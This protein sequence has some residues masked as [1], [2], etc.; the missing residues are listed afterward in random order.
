MRALGYM[1]TLVGAVGVAFSAS[2][3]TTISY[4]PSAEAVGE[5]PRAAAPSFASLVERVTTARDERSL[6][7]AYAE[8]ARHAD[9]NF[10]EM[11]RVV[12]SPTGSLEERTVAAWALGERGGPQACNAVATASGANADSTLGYALALARG[13]CG[14]TSALR[15]VLERSSEDLTYRAKAAAALGLLQDRRSLSI[16]ARLMD[17]LDEGETRNSLVV[18]RG[19]MGDAGVR[20]ELLELLKSRTMHMH[21]A[22]ALARLGYDATIFDVIAATRSRESILRYAA[23][24]LVISKRMTGACTALEPLAGDNDKRVAELAGGA[25]TQWETTAWN[26]WVAEGFALDHFGPRAYCP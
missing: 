16:V 26:E 23:A 11:S 19:L 20:E 1:L 5:A 24:E 10:D 3:Q 25:L 12:A 21:A 2:A 14:D 15:A 4:S 22:I 7:A 13:R 9:A 8:A 17:G 6:H 18:A